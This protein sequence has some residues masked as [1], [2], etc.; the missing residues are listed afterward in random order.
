MKIK[1]VLIMVWGKNKF[2]DIYPKQEIKL[3]KETWVTI[4][5][6]EKHIVGV[7]TNYRSDKRGV[8]CDVTLWSKHVFVDTVSPALRCR[9][10][11]Y[12]NDERINNDLELVGL[13]M[14]LGHAN[15]ECDGNLLSAKNKK[16]TKRRRQEGGV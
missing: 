16:S 1:D 8:F 6:D 9:C 12:L 14:T 15:K 3:P 2:N 10:V 11:K 4:N 5:F 13:S 7:A